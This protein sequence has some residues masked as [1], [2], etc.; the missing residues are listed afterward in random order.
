M[1]YNGAMSH[2]RERRQAWDAILASDDALGAEHLLSGT[3]QTEAY[4]FLAA[5]LAVTPLPEN[6]L[7][8][9]VEAGALNPQS[10]MSWVVH[11]GKR[12]EKVDWG[13]A[14]AWRAQSVG[15]EAAEEEIKAG[16]KRLYSEHISKYDPRAQTLVKRAVVGLLD[17]MPELA[18]ELLTQHQYGEKHL[19]YLAMEP[20]STDWLEQSGLPIEPIILGGWREREAR[21]SP[22][23]RKMGG[24]HSSIG[25]HMG[26]AEDR[27]GSR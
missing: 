7:L 13:Q 4:T 27:R 18:T 23:T 24:L 14:L 21:Y 19:F 11:V 12:N 5:A 9:L 17:A 15:K 25:C 22:Q 2:H 1:G 20:S 3:T 26:L 16:A 6:A 8:A 10:G